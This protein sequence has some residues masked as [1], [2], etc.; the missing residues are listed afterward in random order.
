MKEKIKEYF[1]KIKEKGFVLKLSL[2]PFACGLLYAIAGSDNTPKQVRRFGIPVLL[3]SFAWLSLKNIW[4][5]MML[6]QIGVYSIG[7]GI[8]A[9]NYPENPNL[10]SGS[11]VGRFF[12]RIFRKLFEKN[13]SIIA[14]RREAHYWSNYCVRGTKAL[15]IAISC[16]V[17][18]IL[19]KNWLVYFIL[20]TV[21]VGL[22]ASIAWR[23]MGEKVIK[24]GNKVY[25]VLYVDV[26]VGT[27]IGFYVMLILRF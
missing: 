18:P 26:I 17:I 8:P 21:M 12:V 19:E 5:L 7:H 15:L 24:I 4:V 9:E 3:T 11:V 23:G 16:L 22:I 2:I 6:S 20:S 14:G 1:S 10:D 27:I 13:K 25:T